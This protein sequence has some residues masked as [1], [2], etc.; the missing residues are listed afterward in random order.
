MA[1]SLG[2]FEKGNYGVIPLTQIQEANNALR[3]LTEY[4]KNLKTGTQ[5]QL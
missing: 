1:H 2:V 3:G 4:Q 5:I